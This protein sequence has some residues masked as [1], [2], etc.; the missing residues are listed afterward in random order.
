MTKRQELRVNISKH[1]IFTNELLFPLRRIIG[2]SPATQYIQWARKQIILFL[3]VSSSNMKFKL[4]QRDH[5]AGSNCLFHVLTNTSY[6]H[7]SMWI[8]TAA[9]K[10]SEYDFIEH[11][12]DCYGPK[13]Q[14][15]VCSIIR[16]RVDQLMVA[17]ATV[18]QVQ[19]ID[20]GGCSS[21]VLVGV[22]T[23]GCHSEKWKPLLN[24]LLWSIQL[25]VIRLVLAWEKIHITLFPM[26]YGFM[27]ALV[28]KSGTHLKACC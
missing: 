27:L 26:R 7:T 14:P 12:D 15:S 16:W 5:E 21:C 8:S 9:R 4:I 23:T 22:C 2:V 24:L 3:M 28:F 1:N 18:V 17:N 19:T 25:N 20:D 6:R 13:G 10:M 11:L